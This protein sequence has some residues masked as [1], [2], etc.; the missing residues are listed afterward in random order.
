[1]IFEKRYNDVVSIKDVRLQFSD[2]TVYF[3][4]KKLEVL[5]NQSTNTKNI[6]CLFERMYY[7][8]SANNKISP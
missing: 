1:M 6:E 3:I 7:I 2:L 5:V 8:I 4:F